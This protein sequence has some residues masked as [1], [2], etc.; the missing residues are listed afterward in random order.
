M[1]VVIIYAST[2]EEMVQ[3]CAALVREAIQFQS[4]WEAGRW[5]ITCLG[6]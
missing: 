2:V 5:R 1:P 4:I 3:I 6:F